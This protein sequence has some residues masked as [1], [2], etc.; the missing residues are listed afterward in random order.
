MHSY[1]KPSLAENQDGSHKALP[2]EARAFQPKQ[3]LYEHLD[4]VLGHRDI[5]LVGDWIDDAHGFE[6]E[7][8]YL[9]RGSVIGAFNSCHRPCEELV[10]QHFAEVDIIPGSVLAASAVVRA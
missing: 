10:D 8:I 4:A 6:R 7:P 9:V 5:V 1:I 2:R 3:T